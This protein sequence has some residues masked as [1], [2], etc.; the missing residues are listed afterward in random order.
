MLGPAWDGDA[1][2]RPPKALFRGM[3]E[4]SAPTGPAA[5]PVLAALADTASGTS[6]SAPPTDRAGLAPAGEAS[7]QRG[8]HHF[9]PPQVQEWVATYASTSSI[10]CSGGCAEDGF[11]ALPTHAMNLFARKSAWLLTL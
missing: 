7:D 3:T 9:G 8:E 10:G 11:A 6:A 5:H 1:A 4:L 2:G